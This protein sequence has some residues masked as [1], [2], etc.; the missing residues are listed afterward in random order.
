LR[1]PRGE[2]SHK[3][4]ARTNHGSVWDCRSLKFRF[5]GERT[6]AGAALKISETSGAIKRLDL[7][8]TFCINQLFGCKGRVL[9]RK[10]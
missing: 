7:R 1:L 6:P 2:T 4:G 9:S 10:F 5:D 8:L 3:I